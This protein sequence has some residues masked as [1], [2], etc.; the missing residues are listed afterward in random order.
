MFFCTHLGWQCENKVNLLEIQLIILFCFHTHTYILRD[1]FIRQVGFILT[2]FNRI[3]IKTIF[4]NEENSLERKDEWIHLNEVFHSI[5]RKMHGN[6]N[7]IAV[8]CEI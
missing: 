7:D 6:E 3:K 2:I 4:T 5:E 1:V 8:F